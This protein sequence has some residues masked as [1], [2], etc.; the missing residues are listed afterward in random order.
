MGCKVDKEHSNKGHHVE[1]C[2]CK[3][4]DDCNKITC[5]AAGLRKYK[6]KLKGQKKKND[7]KANLNSVV[8]LICGILV[9]LIN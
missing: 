9:Q 6:S 4:S 5:S 1:V 7:V 8:A 3:L 2:F